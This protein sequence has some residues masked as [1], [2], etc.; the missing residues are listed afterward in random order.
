MGNKRKDNLFQAA[1]T[2]AW[3]KYLANNNHTPNNRSTFK[4]NICPNASFISNNGYELKTKLGYHFA[5][6]SF[7]EL[8]RCLPRN[9]ALT[10]I[11]A[12]NNDAVKSNKKFAAQ[13]KINDLTA[14]AE[15][16][17]SIKKL[18][19]SEIKT[20][21]IKSSSLNDNSSRTQYDSSH[22]SALNLS[23]M[24][25]VSGND[26]KHADKIDQGKGTANQTILDTDK[27]WGIPL[28]LILPFLLFALAST[29]RFLTAI[30][31][32]GS[33]L[34]YPITY[35]QKVKPI[36]PSQPVKPI[37]IPEQGLLK[38]IM[39]CIK[40]HFAYSSE[41]CKKNKEVFRLDNATNF[42]IGTYIASLSGVK[43]M[44]YYQAG[45]NLKL[46]A[47][48]SKDPELKGIYTRKEIMLCT[49]NM[50]GS[51]ESSLILQ[52]ELVHAAQDCNGGP[53]SSSPLLKRD[54]LSGPLLNDDLN[55][56]KEIYPKEKWVNEFEARRGVTSGLL[57]DT[58]VLVYRACM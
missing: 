7:S 24:S 50:V 18:L 35:D 13:Q 5:T 52:H 36:L 14:V 55:I 30:L 49:N 31:L 19:S 11:S 6:I 37:E 38:A 34:K 48:C 53:L 57:I 45:V 46:K 3:N 4:A 54:F 20:Q 41:Y 26:L 2:A 9:V 21:P 32:N 29:Q 16:A 17:K 28:L 33:H 39:G 1:V 10:D 12:D 43:V 51:M 8:K 56:V 22:Y 15:N 44:G 40:G 23:R 42:K 58:A 27:R 25:N 47:E